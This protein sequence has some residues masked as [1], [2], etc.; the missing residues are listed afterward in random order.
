[1]SYLGKIKFFIISVLIVVLVVS[2]R[3]IS[4]TF[5]NK[6]IFL[7]LIAGTLYILF[8]GLT[9][10]LQSV[11]Q[12]FNKFRAIFFGETIFQFFRII[13]ISLAV[14]LSLKFALSNELLLFYLFLALGVS[15]LLV[16]LFLGYILIRKVKIFG[17]EKL[18]LSGKQKKQTN[19]FLIALS[20]STLSGILFSYIDR[21]ML[22][23][24]VAAEFIGYYTIA[25]SFVSAASVFAGFGSA[26]LPIF[27]RVNKN[28]LEIGFKKSIKLS[29]IFGIVSTI[30]ILILA[31]PIISIIYGR[32]YLAATNLL[33]LLSLSFFTLPLSGLYTVYFMSRNKPQ[34]IA[35]LSIISTVLNI[36]LNYLLITTLL[37]YS[38]FAA[39]FGAGI[40]L[41]L[42][43]FFYIAALEIAR[44]RDLKK[45]NKPIE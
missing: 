45:E 3:F 7:A 28:K 43:Q 2:A 14:L 10:L 31:S 6:P 40:A 5:Y 4:N 26:L 19:K 16:A 17:A 23:H 13:L 36:V 44:R 42:S 11:L 22:G 18:V 15:Y 21:I 20:A 37:G 24:F 25:L 38:S 1:L 9:L 39:T 34:I 41:L 35:K 32:E 30:L 29:L 33:R 27:S 12:S 8:Y